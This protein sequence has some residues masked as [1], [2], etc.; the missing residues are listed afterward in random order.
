MVLK[1]FSLISEFQNINR[2]LE[3]RLSRTTKNILKP[4]FFYKVEPREKTKGGLFGGTKT[5]FE[6]GA[7]CRKKTV[8]GK[9]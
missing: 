6:K 3:K 4:D 8:G 2:D 5:F 9:T 7:R 1:K